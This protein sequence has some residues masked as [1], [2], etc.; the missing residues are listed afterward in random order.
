MR[1]QHP[2]Q[3]LCYISRDDLKHS[4]LLAAAG[5]YILTLDITKGEV[6]S[7]W[8]QHTSKHERN[9]NSRDG[10]PPEKKRRL[11]NGEDDVQADASDSS[12]SVEIKTERV[13]GQ[14]RKPKPE[15]PLPNVS[16]VIAALDGT[17]V[18]ITAED[19]C[20]RTFSITTSGA[21]GLLA[22]RIMPKRPCAVS[23]NPSEDSIIVG[24][25][26]G[27][28]Y[29]L[30]LHPGSDVPLVESRKL[31]KYGAP[32]ASESTVHTK[33]NLEALKQQRLL[34]ESDNSDKVTKENNKPNFS[35]SL[36]LGHVSLL[37][38]LLISDV[39]PKISQGDSVHRSYIIT[40]DRDE[41]IRIS[42]LPQPYMIE[43]YCYGHGSFI[44]CLSVGGVE[45]NILISGSGAPEI[46]TH[47][48]P[49][50]RLLYR[51]LLSPDKSGVEH[52]NCAVSGIWWYRGLILVALEGQPLLYPIQIDSTTG[53]LRSEKPIHLPGNV[54]DV[55]IILFPPEQ[56]TTVRSLVAVSLDTAH[57]KG[58]MRNTAGETTL[59]S[60]ESI[61]FIQVLD[62]KKQPAASD[63]DFDFEN[64]SLLDNLN[65]A[66]VTF[67]VNVTASDSRDGKNVYSHLG[68]FLYGRENLRKKGFKQMQKDETE[69]IDDNTFDLIAEEAESLVT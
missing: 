43:S 7:R 36:L 68:E 5:P 65:E 2:F 46:L 59:D 33:R 21:L 64:L 38:A 12:T 23:L 4:L 54:L 42:R 1:L 20:I 18:T 14:R 24:D 47:D 34:R 53:E 57:Q 3:K 27:D 6:L 28:V 32:S 44:T 16:H 8:P 45:R 51:L 25:K 63:G 55:A 39:P 10:Q 11:S 29:S 41:H 22:E 50:G 48:I 69:D 56:H 31:W 30:P 35:S 61:P 37:T 19:K 60:H 17:I 26:F 62:L 49:S 15:P 58:S 9:T 13:K 40:S 67:D 52:A 66:L